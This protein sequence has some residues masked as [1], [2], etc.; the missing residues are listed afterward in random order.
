MSNV[1]SKGGDR[2]CQT[3]Y[4]L[5]CASEP[6]PL[7]RLPLVPERWVDERF[8][9][10]HEPEFVEE[11]IRSLKHVDCVSPVVIGVLRAIRAAKR[12]DEAGERLAAHRAIRRTEFG[13]EE[14]S[15][16]DDLRRMQ[17]ATLRQRVGIK[18][19]RREVSDERVICL[20]GGERRRG[21]RRG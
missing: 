8:E 21:R 12:A 9:R 10:R 15:V 16:K 5:N 11:G 19:P 18:V 3:V 20:R 6:V 17:K 7:S 1:V 14:N 13:V 4:R 2:Q